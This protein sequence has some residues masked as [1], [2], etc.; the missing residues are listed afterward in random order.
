MRKSVYFIGLLSLVGAAF[1]AGSLQGRL[2]NAPAAGS[3]A[4]T[5]AP[6]VPTVRK[7]LRYTCPM[8]PAYKSDSPGKA[9][10]CGMDLEPVYASAEAVTAELSDLPGRSAPIGAETRKVIGVAVE[11]VERSA[12]THTFRLF[13]RVVPD[14]TR[15]YRLNAGIDGYIKSVSD[16][17]T[18]SRV[19]KNQ[20]L[21]TFA[22]PN[23]Q[24]VIQTYILNLG[25]QDRFRKAA[26]EGTAEGQSVPAAD[27]NVQQ[28]ID[29]MHN[30]GIS[31]LQ[32]EEIDRAR[33]IP[34]ALKILSPVDG[35]VLARGVSPGLK[36][37]R[38][39]EWYRIADLRKVWI[40]ADVFENE[41]RYLK[42]GT[43]AEVSCSDG[44]SSVPARVAEVLPQFDAA[45]R[46]MKVRLEADNPG[47][48]LRPEMF[49]DVEVSVA[50]A[51]TI[52]VPLE[53]V[54]D[55]G[56]KKTVF[57]ERS[58]GVF[59]PRSVRTGWRFGDRVEIV[60]GL[61]AG[62]RIVVSG[63]FF[64]DSESRMKTASA[65]PVGGEKRP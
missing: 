1:L 32:M 15:V 11:P 24:G 10:C 53:S 12:G 31:A 62:E 59:E 18:G 65:A 52:S 33:R 42:P 56:L 50:Y 38:G 58:E 47:D 2:R 64:L 43:R 17:T 5:S 37:D 29:Q 4:A 45:T 51:P 57:V 36:F 26:A 6:A 60:G 8:H 25:A 34:P 40:L 61:A 46:T 23:G 27:G 44:R 9:P 7:V 28:R 54:L 22:A 39:M 20:E 21:A 35:F 41:A 14:E 13:G 16:V 48:V 55:S 49:V 30:M 19:R 63:T 3:T